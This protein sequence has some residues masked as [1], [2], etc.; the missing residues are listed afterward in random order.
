[1]TRAI[2]W[3]SSAP[4][5]CRRWRCRSSNRRLPT[6]FARARRAA[7]L[8]HGEVRSFCHAAPARGA[9]ARPRRDAAGAAIKRQG[10][11][12]QRRLRQGR[13]AHARPR[14]VRRKVRRDVAALTRVTEGKGEFLFFAGSKPGAAT[15]A[16]AAGH[17]AARAR[18]SCRSPSA[19]AGA[20]ASARVRAA[21]ALAGDAVRRG[22]DSGAHP[23]HRSRRRTRAGIASWRRRSSRSRSL[24]TTRPCCARQGK[25]IAGFRR[26]PRADR[27]AGRRAAAESAG[28]RRPA[29]RCAAR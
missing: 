1:M 13:Q 23:R 8:A 12:G 15:P 3:S 25:V 28:R 11:A 10:S 2:F 29:E 26:A 21:G 18:C 9:G 17:R 6:A 7:G 20:R 16:P 19:C 4:K 5:S 27:R 24:P 14:E 22:C